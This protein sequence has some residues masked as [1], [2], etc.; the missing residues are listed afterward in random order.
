[1][2]K[3]K[4]EIKQFWPEMLQRVQTP[5]YAYRRRSWVFSALSQTILNRPHSRLTAPAMSCLRLTHATPNNSIRVEFGDTALSKMSHEPCTKGAHPIEEAGEV[6]G[7]SQGS[8]DK[9]Y[10]RH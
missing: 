6:A 7:E 8:G 4:T 9:D 2:G 1:M 3:K 10:V 5:G